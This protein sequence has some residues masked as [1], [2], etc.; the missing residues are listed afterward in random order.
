MKATQILPSNYQSTGKF[1]LNSTKQI[2]FMN[3]IGLVI[4]IV[5][6]WFFPW[7]VKQFRPEFNSMFEFKFSNFSNIAI[8]LIKLILPIILVLVVHEAI[9][10]FFFW[11]FSKQKPVVGFKGAYAYAAL[12]GWYFP[13]NQYLFIGL[14]PLLFIT[15]IGLVLLFFLPVSTLNMVLIALI[16]NTSGAAGDLFVVSWLLTKPPSTYALD[17]IDTIEFFTTIDELS[18]NS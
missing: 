17:E 16:I 8:G 12:P 18:N 4:L 10:T 3:V 7:Y 14:A 1:D 11:I 13:R 5:S 2:I 9:H 6:L 15:L